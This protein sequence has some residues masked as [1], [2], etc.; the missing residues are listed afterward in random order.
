MTKL[1][2]NTVAGEVG[3]FW[4]L[5]NRL[6]QNSIPWHD[7]AWVDIDG[8]HVYNFP[9]DHYSF[10][11]RLK[12]HVPAIADIEYDEIPRGRVILNKTVRTFYVY[13]PK[14]EI[15]SKKIQDLIKTGFSL[16]GKKIVFK[17]DPHY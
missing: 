1:L 6:I 2:K 9:V 17:S 14:K 15:K 8:D 16:Y 10:W 11:E 12:I 4:I 7:A 3:I 13:G 5:D